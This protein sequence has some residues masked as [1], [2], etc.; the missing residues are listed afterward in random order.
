[1]AQSTSTKPTPKG[2]VYSDTDS[3]VEVIYKDGKWGSIEN[4]ADPYIKLHMSAATLH[5]GQTI[6]EGLKAH[7]GKDGKVRLFR[8]DEN[9]KRFNRSAAR[10][11]M[12]QVDVSFF[13]EAV[14]TAV[15]S[16]MSYVPDHG[17]GSLYIRPFMFATEAVVGLDPSKEYK[18]L[19]Y[20][21]PVGDFY[22]G[23]VQSIPAFVV[24]NYDRA[25][26]R[27]VGNVKVAGN[28][29][30]A[31]ES[32]KKAKANGFPITL[33][34]DAQ[35]RSY[36]EEFASSNFVAISKD[37]SKYLTPESDS[38]LP[39]ITNMSLEVLASDLGLIV[40]RRPIAIT[41][42]SEFSEVGAVG[43]AVVCSPISKIVYGDSVISIPGTKDSLGPV[44]QKL[45]IALKEIH[46]GEAADTHNWNIVV[47][48]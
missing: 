47:E 22:S 43:T 11:M 6:F 27:G 26:P 29:A 9:A 20:V 45:Y 38:I 39:S 19:V 16:N 12:P 35:T 7:K 17:A 44:L 24:D 2:F 5:Y 36:V 13:I 42:V 15:R 46:Q 10:L 8:P 34:L 37:G 14:M 33:F 31:M 40:E 18:F 32:S 1:M 25:A 30:A 48:P 28:Y 23:A 21:T 41:E 3:H 4:V